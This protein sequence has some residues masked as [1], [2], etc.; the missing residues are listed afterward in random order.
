MKKR[1]IFFVLFILIFQ[2][3]IFSFVHADDKANWGLLY[4]VIDLVKTQYVKKEISEKNLVYGSIKGV[5]K[6]FDDPYSRF[7]EPDNFK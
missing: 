5:L 3:Y 1:I 7:L 6:S 2:V 4:R